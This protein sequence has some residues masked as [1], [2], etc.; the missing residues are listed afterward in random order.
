MG[1]CYYHGL[2]NPGCPE[3]ELERRQKKTQDDKEVF[4]Y[5]P[6]WTDEEI[7]PDLSDDKEKNT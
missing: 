3:C 5:M 4:V 6:T 2:S 1:E 7:F